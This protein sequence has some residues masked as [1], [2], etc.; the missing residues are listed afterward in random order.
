MKKF[1]KDKLSEILNIRKFIF[2]NNDKAAEFLENITF[3]FS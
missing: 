3:Y 2:D 1:D